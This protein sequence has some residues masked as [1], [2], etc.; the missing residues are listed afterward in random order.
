MFLSIALYEFKYMFLSLQSL[1]IAVLFFSIA[2]LLTANSVE[3][4]MIAQGG[5]VFINSPYSITVLMVFLSLFATFIIPSFMA[6]T[7]IKDVDHKFDAILF[8]TPI[9][10][11]SY[12]LGRYIGSFLALILVLSIAPLGMYLGTFWPWA[13]PETLAVNNHNHYLIAFFAY[14]IPSVFT[15]SALIFAVA[16]TTRSMMYSYLAS[17][18]VFILY[19]TTVNSNLISSLWDPFMVELVFEKT[20]Y[21]TAVELNSQLL[22]Y[23]GKVLTNRLIWFGF[24]L[25]VLGL[26]YW[27]FSFAKSTKKAKDSKIESGINEIPLKQNIDTD[28][29]I[30]ADW[31]QNVPLK[32]FLYRTGFEIKS[33]LMSKPFLLLMAYSFFMLFFALTGRQTS[34]DVNRYPLTLLMIQSIAGTLTLALMA[35][36]AFYSADVI[37]R[38]R[39]AK[40]NEIIDAMPAANWIFVVSKVTALVLVMFCIV[41]LGVVIAISIQILSGF[42][43]IKLSRYLSLSM[44]YYTI[45]YIFL[46]VLTCFFQVLAKNRVIGLLLFVIFTTVVALSHDIFGVRHILL[47]YVLPGVS[48]PLSDMNYDSRF[49]ETGL[50]ARIYWGSMA[51]ILLILTYL[52]WNRG[53][54]QP[55]KYRLRNLTKVKAKGFGL[56]LFMM[57][58][59]FLGSGSYIFYNT[60]VLNEYYTEMDTDQIQLSYE[61]EYS[62]YKSLPMPDTVDVKI[63]VDIFPYKRRV[64]TRSTQILENK[65]NQQINSIHLTFPFNVEIIRVELQ[66]AVIKTADKELSYYIFDLIQPMLPG[67]KLNLTFENLIQQQG[68]PNSDPDTRLVRNGTFL[69]STQLS[70]Y[71]GFCDCI[72][73]QEESKRKEYGLQPLPGLAK[74]EDESH[75]NNS[76][77]RKDSDYIN[78]QAVVSTV[79]GQRAI[80]TGHL[81]DDWIQGDRS[82]FSYKIDQ[83]ILNTYSFVSAEYESTHDQWQDVAIDVFYHQEHDYNIDTMIQ[84]IKDSLDYYSREFSAYQY[85]QVRILEFPSYTKKAQAFAGTIPFSEG[86]GFIADVR[87]PEGFNLPYYVTAHEMAHQWWAHQVMSAHTQGGVMLLETLAQ[88]SAVMVLEKQLGIGQTRKFLKLELDKYLTGRV[89]ELEGEQ[90]LYKV[91]D[92]AYIYYRKGALVMYALREYMGEDAINRALRNL[93]KNHAYQSAPYATTLDFLHY[94]KLEVGPSHHAMIEDFLEKITLYDFKANQAT[95]AQMVDG[96]YKVTVDIEANKMYQDSEGNQTH[97][98]I[99]LP[100]EIGLFLRHPNDDKFIN[101]DII[102]LQKQQIQTGASSIEFIANIKPL[103]VGVDPFNILIDRDINDNISSVNERE[104]KNEK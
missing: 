92:Q 43:D 9:T 16:I 30:V 18:G 54:L 4:T 99:K 14:L 79:S 94:L 100:I 98:E 28:N 19:I 74:L 33:V 71:I 37:W 47:S 53:T 83:P 6:T 23:S 55:F 24:S 96:R 68:F 90:P 88:Y 84:S 80:T 56:P 20:K 72:S 49:F 42:Y 101:D 12:L 15:L 22:G 32:Q 87:N 50:W 46:A 57:L 65:T 85:K 93:I 64:E 17:L 103:F 27:V 66:G 75:Y 67:E 77:I 89:S 8:S 2:F 104:N 35:I 51:G 3:F 25:C 5:Q 11:T 97:T 61:R 48:A 41:L 34:Y 81:V 73:I 40:F 78:Y 1:V 7:V 21:W 70:P 31:N 86:I 58:T 13:T 102:V 39:T 62:Q 36:L 91:E 60:N 69:S 44:L 59:L 26:G 29:N 76:Y 82:Y 10:K 63:E 38:E 95:V 52:F 45:P